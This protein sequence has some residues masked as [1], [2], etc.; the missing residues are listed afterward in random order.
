MTVPM[1]LN[2]M[3]INPPPPIPWMAW[4]AINWGKD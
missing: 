3:A 2:A 4:K 1:I